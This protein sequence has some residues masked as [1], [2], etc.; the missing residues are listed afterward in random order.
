M[1]LS[2]LI[3]SAK[4][5]NKNSKVEAVLKAE[6][7][8]LYEIY[9]EQAL[10]TKY[11][12]LIE[13][14]VA[15]H[16]YK[17]VVNYAA[18]DL[19]FVDKLNDTVIEEKYL[20][21]LNKS[22]ESNSIYETYVSVITSTDNKSMVLYHHDGKYTYFT[23]QHL[24]VLFDDETLET[25]K[26]IDGYD[27][28]KDAKFRSVYE[29]IRAEYA[30]DS[31]MKTT[32]RDEDGYK[33]E[34]TEENLKT[35]EAI[36]EEFAMEV[37]QKESEFDATGLTA[38][39]EKI[40]R[41]RIRTLLFNEYI[42]KYGEDP[43]SM[44]KDAL[45]SILGYVVSEEADEHGGLAKDFANG[46]RELYNNY[47]A[48]LNGEDKNPALNDGIGQQIVS[49][50]SDIGVHMMMLT[51]VYEAGAIAEDIDD[52]KAKYVSNL[53]NQKLYDYVYDMVKE[54][55]VGDNGTYF[56][57]YAT[58]LVKHYKDANL[59]HWIDKMSIQRLKDA[60]NA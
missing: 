9:Y 14:T 8:R 36:R 35:I 17:G 56:S 7:E 19:K 6:V 41:T 50:V 46:A 12:E 43:G 29:K 58:E 31:L 55:L 39:E 37:A 33:L 13:T 51:D 3:F 18:E 53:T 26:E 10:L 27:S 32:A 42:W 22:A 47:L 44:T 21:L 23:V 20:D 30:K 5:N 54:E 49:V 57:D 16:N 4:A 34:K 38:E 48:E 28:T 1:Y 59:V 40:A 11:R 2:D 15:G 52:L 25:L 24:V 45:T 60:I